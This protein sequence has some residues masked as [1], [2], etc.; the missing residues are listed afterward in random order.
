MENIF[1]KYEIKREYVIKIKINGP[2]EYETKEKYNINSDQW[3][4]ISK[5]L[6]EEYQE[7]LDN[8]NPC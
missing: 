4:R 1:E 2:H 7:K 3:T 5:I 8:I 6:M